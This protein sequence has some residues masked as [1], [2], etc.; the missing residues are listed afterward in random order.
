MAEIGTPAF[1]ATSRG[2]LRWNGRE[3]RCALGRTGVVANNLK[4]EGDGATPLG[5]WPM[6]RVFWRP[7]RLAQ[8]LTQLPVIALSPG[9]GWCDDPGHPDYNRQV[10]LPF[11]ASH[12][13]LWREDD[14]YDLIIVLGYNDDPVRPGR[15]SAIF[16]HLA[17]PDFSFTEGCIACA[18]QDL[19]D[20]LAV[21]KPGDAL[22]IVL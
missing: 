2:K 15:G 12:E 16:L 20:L 8:P 3:T 14:V 10:A 4:R 6:R 21:A 18:R 17:R 1:E 13:T 5:V 7:D 11:P 19:L 22:S 9:T